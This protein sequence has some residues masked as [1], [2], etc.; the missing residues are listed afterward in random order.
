MQYSCDFYERSRSMKAVEKQAS[1]TTESL[2]LFRR[3]GSTTYRVGIYFNPAAKETLN[4]K[5]CRLLKNDL[6]SPP[7][8]AT[9]E[10]LQ[11]ARLSERGTL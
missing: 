10:P 11:A 5:V 4:E 7:A 3:I 6:H 1:A 2:V 9:M 8:N